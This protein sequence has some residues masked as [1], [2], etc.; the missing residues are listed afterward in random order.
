MRKI[1]VAL[2]ALALAACG[3]DDRQGP[4]D[5]VDPR[6]QPTY[7]LDWRIGPVID[8]QNYSKGM[9]PH[10]LLTGDGFA[11]PLSGRSE[12][13][14]V[15]RDSDQLQPGGRVVMRFRVENEEGSR[16]VGKS[17]PDQPAAVVV[18]L[19]REG[20]DWRRDG[21]RWWYT[22]GR[23]SVSENGEHEIVAPFSGLWTSVDKMASDSSPGEFANA[24]RDADQIGFT[25]GDCESQGHGALSTGTSRVIVTY[26]GVQ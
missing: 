23:T 20:D 10:P 6:P 2:T 9:P 21:Y 13:H 15:T 18:Y 8:G 1:T 3:D 24:L 11:V 12:P 19:Q 5:G 17:C 14:Y 16:I 25:F 4:I 7:A 22:P 26:F